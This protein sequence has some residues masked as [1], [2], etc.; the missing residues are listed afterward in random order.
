M[1]DN[2]RD[3]IIYANVLYPNDVKEVYQKAK[4]NFLKGYSATSSDG[5]HFKW[6]YRLSKAETIND[7]IVYLNED[8][9]AA[10]ISTAIDTSKEHLE[11]KKLSGNVSLV[12][13]KITSL[14]NQITALSSTVA[15]LTSD[16][17]IKDEKIKSLQDE[18]KDLKEKI[19][20][21]ESDIT[22]IVNL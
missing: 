16:S 13:D 6:N 4:D 8:V 20:S 19:K 17:T 9:K 12:K 10:V 14:K 15:K 18:N 21:L 3:D 2:I 5:R 22:E 11:D 7:E 1:M